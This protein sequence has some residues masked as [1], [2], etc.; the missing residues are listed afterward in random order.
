[1]EPLADYINRLR[2]L[3]GI[4]KKAR[5]RAAG[6]RN[7]GAETFEAFATLNRESLIKAYNEAKPL[8]HSVKLPLEAVTS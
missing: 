6:A 5:Q 7:S 2:N 8:P 4:C 1:M 3:C